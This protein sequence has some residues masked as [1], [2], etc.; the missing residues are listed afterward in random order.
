[1]PLPVVHLVTDPMCSW[2]WG[3]AA[4]FD[5][6]R[7]RLA[8]LVEFELLLGGINTH[9]TQPVGDYGRRYLTRLWREVEAT[10][11][12]PFGYRF[13]EDYVHNSTLPCMAVEAVRQVAGEVPFDYLRYLQSLFFLQ[14]ENINALDKLLE[15]ATDLGLSAPAVAAWIKN[16]SLAQRVRFQFE[17]AGAFG[18]QAMPSLLM[19]NAPDGELTLLAGGYVDAAMLTDLVMARLKKLG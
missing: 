15:A 5:Q 8:G 2:C 1:M 12:Q 7:A 10:T 14:A 18:T 4:D 6:A 16:D 13:P 11:G 19:Q 9:G 17:H 3:M